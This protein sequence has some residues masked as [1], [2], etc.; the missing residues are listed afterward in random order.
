MSFFTKLLYW[1]NSLIT[2]FVPV[3]GAVGLIT[4]FEIYNSLLI[5]STGTAK[6]Q[7]AQHALAS[8]IRNFFKFQSKT[9][10]IFISVLGLIL[11]FNS[12]FGLL[13]ALSFVFGGACILIPL[14][15]ASIAVTEANIRAVA[16]AKDKGRNEAFYLCFCGSAISGLSFGSTILLGFGLLFYFFNSAYSVQYFICFTFGAALVAYIILFKACILEASIAATKK[17]SLEDSFKESQLLLIYTGLDYFVCCLSLL[18]AAIIIAASATPELLTIL[19][20]ASL[21]FPAEEL[22]KF[23]FLLMAVPLILSLLGIISSIIGIKLVKNYKDEDPERA[24]SVAS[25][26]ST[27]LFLIFS[28]LLIFSPV[29]FK[30]LAVV[31][32]GAIVGILVFYFKI[33]QRI[34]SALSKLLKLEECSSLEVI[35]QLV[36]LAVVMLLMNYFAGAYGFAIGGVSLFSVLAINYS[37]HSFGQIAASANAIAEVSDLDAETKNS[38][39]ELK[40]IGNKAASQ[41]G[42]YLRFASI[43]TAICLFIAYTQSAQLDELVLTDLYVIAGLLLGFCSPGFASA[44]LLS[45]IVDFLN[46]DYSREDLQEFSEKAIIVNFAILLVL[47]FLIGILLGKDAL[48]AFSLSC[49]L[50]SLPLVFVSSRK[51]IVVNDK[52]TIKSRGLVAHQIFLIKMLPLLCL[53]FA[54]LI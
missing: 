41:G 33:Q 18:T 11:F 42:A 17:D 44:L 34:E 23:N 37:I 54:Y 4:A 2:I 50:A 46:K 49:L 53:L 43:I 27:S 24:L 38:L 5:E 26:M 36:L 13:G 29:K 7:E 6:M 52:C 40:E 30:V 25:L 28:F 21:D 1:F 8:M 14:Y 20:T 10:I 39:L 31:L 9:L 16:V 32:L 51:E 15:F 3:A 48:G 22:D 19:T 35:S 12:S 47:P 45:K